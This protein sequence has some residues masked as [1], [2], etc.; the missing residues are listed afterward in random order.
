MSEQEI[1]WPPYVYFSSVD[2]HP[3]FKEWLAREMLA[4]LGGHLDEEANLQFYKGMFAFT[5]HS[6]EKD[7]KPT[8]I[9]GDFTDLMEAW[10]TS[11][12]CDAANLVKDIG[13]YKNEEPGSYKW[14]KN[15]ISL[16]VIDGTIT[17]TKPTTR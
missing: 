13:L 9:I 17:R 2:I 3:T 10:C 7:A 5:S 8:K 16:R 12:R 6:S 14:L 11:V 4:A 1:K 15:I